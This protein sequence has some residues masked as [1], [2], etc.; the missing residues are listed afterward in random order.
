MYFGF[1]VVSFFLLLFLSLWVCGK[2]AGGI[3][4]AKSAEG[5]E[6]LA[7]VRDSELL[8]Y[9]VCG[10]PRTGLLCLGVGRPPSAEGTD[11][12]NLG[13]IVS[14]SNDGCREST[15]IVVTLSPQAHGPTD[16]N[17]GGRKDETRKT[18]RGN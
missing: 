14:V 6:G 8:L 4:L 2:A 9:G 11:L 16:S 13:A 5:G 15:A 1:V 10:R 7:E 17:T 18:V 3:E 12:G